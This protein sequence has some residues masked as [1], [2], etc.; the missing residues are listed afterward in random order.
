M[1]ALAL[2]KRATEND[3]FVPSGDQEVQRFLEVFR[4]HFARRFPI[5]RNRIQSRLL[6]G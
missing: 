5:D 3:S 4:Y 6:A 1:V 2:E